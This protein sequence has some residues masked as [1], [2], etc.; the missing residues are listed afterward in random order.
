MPCQPF[1]Q[2]KQSICFWFPEPVPSRHFI[3]MPE[4]FLCSLDVPRKVAIMYTTER[5]CLAIQNFTKSRSPFQK[6]CTHS[7]WQYSWYLSSWFNRT[8]LSAFAAVINS[9]CRC[10]H[11]IP[12]LCL[13]VEL[14]LSAYALQYAIFYITFLS[15]LL[16]QLGHCTFLITCIF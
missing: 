15:L 13:L 6:N 11:L 8:S 9:M 10:Q 7:S 12:L 16:F 4:V 5:V 2:A 1:Q 14:S 3:Y